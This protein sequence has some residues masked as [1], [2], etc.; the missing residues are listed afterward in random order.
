M[1][2]LLHIAPVQIGHEASWDYDPER[3]P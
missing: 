1:G 2:N 3:S